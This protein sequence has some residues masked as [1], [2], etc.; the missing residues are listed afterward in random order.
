V[1]LFL[2]TTGNVLAD[3]QA[4]RVAF[5]NED[6]K[7]TIELLWVNHDV[8]DGHPGRKVHEATIPP[9]GGAHHS[10]TFVGHEFSYELNGETHYVTPPRP[11]VGGDSDQVVVL[12]GSGEGVRVKCG[13]SVNS[14]SGTDELNI[15]VKPYWA[16][17]GAIRFLELVRSGYYDG[18]AFNRA[19]PQFLIQFGIGASYEMRT[20]MRENSIYDDKNE[21]IRFQPGYV[22]FAGSGPHSR[23]TEIFFVQPDTPR[24]QQDYFGQ[25][26][27]ETPFAYVENVDVLSKIYSGYGDM[28]PWGEGPDPNRIYNID[29]YSD[30]LPVNFPKLDYID[31]CIIVDEVGLGE[32]YS[33]GEF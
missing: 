12:A 29:G 23:T 16:P 27:W 10:N 1:A 8:E 33:E 3:L 26:S 4:M 18:V 20:A 24:H 11:T 5:V 13:I 25:N 30:Y 22:S 32:G 19:V 28:P 31:R 7:A 9:R 15:L 14:Q 6:P 17:R 21:E 2:S